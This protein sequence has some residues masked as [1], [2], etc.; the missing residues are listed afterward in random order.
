M[1]RPLVAFPALL[2]VGVF[3][4][5]LYSQLYPCVLNVHEDGG[6]LRRISN[7]NTAFNC[8]ENFNRKLMSRICQSALP[9]VG[10][11]W[12]TLTLGNSGRLP[13]FTTRGTLTSFLI[14][15]LSQLERPKV[16]SS[17]IQCARQRLKEL[18]E[19]L[20]RGFCNSCY[21]A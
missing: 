12:G 20:G 5:S 19:T 6:S 16:Q 17:D 2:S 13:F 21:G 14:Q 10:L 11:R 7:Q 15:S 8:S 9:S 3:S 4:E 1:D 18:L